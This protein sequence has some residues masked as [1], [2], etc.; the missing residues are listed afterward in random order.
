MFCF[1]ALTNLLFNA[2]IAA[3]SF[4]ALYVLTDRKLTYDKDH[5]TVK[6]LW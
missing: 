4:K 2:L 5:K 3:K 1:P 6:H